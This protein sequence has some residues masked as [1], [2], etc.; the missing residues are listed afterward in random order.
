MWNVSDSVPVKW[1][2]DYYHYICKVYSM[3]CGELRCSHNDVVIELTCDPV[4]Q[5]VTKLKSPT[6][7]A[8]IY[9]SNGQRVVDSGPGLDSD[10]PP[11]PL[12]PTPP[13]QPS[14]RNGLGICLSNQSE[15]AHTVYLPIGPRIRLS[16]TQTE[17]SLQ[18]KCNENNKATIVKATVATNARKDCKRRATRLTTE[19]SDEE[20]K[21]FRQS[22]F[23]LLQDS[24]NRAYED[25]GVCFTHTLS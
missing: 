18:S 25:K 19:D 17:R 5:F 3:I 1:S 14:S 9:D 10:P 15:Q 12:Q 7:H 13:I 22:L 21:R 11:P 4:C 20:Y 23:D 8:I 16:D 2:V 6:W 24:V